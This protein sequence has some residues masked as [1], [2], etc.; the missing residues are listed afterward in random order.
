ML[1][2]LMLSL[3][4]IA[5]LIFVTLPS[6][7]YP[8]CFSLA[9]SLARYVFSYILLLSNV[10]L[11]LPPHLDLRPFSFFSPII[12][13]LVSPLSNSIMTFE[14]YLPHKM[15]HHLLKKTLV[16][17]SLSDV[18]VAMCCLLLCLF[19]LFIIFIGALCN[20]SP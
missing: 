1:L 16:A 7:T 12:S 19:C 15:L 6:T 4:F 3:L 2:F 20:S 5:Y 9:C 8:C 18:H 17:T 11:L 13:I 14:K 10:P